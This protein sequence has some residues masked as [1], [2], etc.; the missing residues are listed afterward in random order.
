[1]L[2]NRHDHAEAHGQTYGVGHQLLARSA[3]DPE[4]IAF[5]KTL[6]SLRRQH[7]GDGMV[8]VDCGA[9]IGVHTLECARAMHGWGKVVAI[10]AQERLF[11]ALAGNIALNNLFNARA[12]W[13]AVGAESGEIGVP[14]PD[15]L[16]PASFGSLELRRTE[17]TE[18]IGQDIDYS[19]QAAQAVRLVALDELGLERV[20]LIKIDVE[21]M[22]ID[23]LRGAAGLIER[24]RPQLLVERIK[25]DEAGL[26]GFLEPRGY[27]LFPLGLNLLAL[28]ASDPVSNQVRVTEAG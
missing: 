14:V 24:F 4:E 27:K 9:N 5:L 15:Y 2:V 3:Y 7:F 21:G 10:E 20:D 26:A 8:M 16:A 17:R 13:A 6:L 1:M 28:H 11:Y 19:P 23:A 12:V 18:H 25:S 22:E